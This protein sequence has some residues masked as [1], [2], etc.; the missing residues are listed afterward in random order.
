MEDE[1]KKMAIYFCED[2]DKFILKDNCLV[3]F[4]TLC[5][6]IMDAKKVKY[7]I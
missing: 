2:V 4:D 7:I 1:R 3:H 5:D 6:K